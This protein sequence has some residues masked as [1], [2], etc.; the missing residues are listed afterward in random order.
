MG[1]ST[2]ALINQVLCEESI[3]LTRLDQNVPIGSISVPAGSEF[4]GQTW[5][6]VLD[7]TLMRLNGVLGLQVS[8]FIQEEL[9][10]TTPQGT[11][12]PLEF[13]FSHRDF[14]PLKNCAQTIG[15]EDNLDELDCRIVSLAGSNQLTLHADQTFDQFLEITIQV[16]L[17]RE[18]QLLI[19]L[20]PPFSIACNN[21]D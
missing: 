16:K 17:L 3:T 20:C 6:S 2:K 19:A 4:S 11:R 8:L 13:G 7:C 10:I 21:Q 15:L 5:I 18:S 1:L 14:A 12:F 9:E